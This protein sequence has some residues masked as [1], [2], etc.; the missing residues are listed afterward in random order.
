MYNYCEMKKSALAFAAVLS[1]LIPFTGSAEDTQYKSSGFSAE[2]TSYGGIKNL[3][4]GDKVFMRHFFLSGDYIP[5]EGVAKHDPRFFQ[6]LEKSLCDISRPDADTM[7]IARKAAVMGNEKY[8]QGA[9][10]NEKITLTPNRISAEYEVEITVPMAANMNIFRALCEL[11]LSFAGCGYKA[12]TTDGKELMAVVPREYSKSDSLKVFAK[13]LAFAIPGGMIT[14]E[15][16][17]STVLFFYDGRSW[18]DDHLRLDISQQTAWHEKPV[19]YQPGAKFKWAFSIS[20][21]PVEQ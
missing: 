7:V 16:D 4:I 5:V 9:T 3:K 19:T 20:Y 12:E 2:V 6:F 15:G 13:K 17:P 21:A 10:Y 14:V 8:P 1:L 11:P 18:N